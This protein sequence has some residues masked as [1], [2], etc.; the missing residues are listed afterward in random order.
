MEG[1]WIIFFNWLWRDSLCA[2]DSLLLNVLG[3][4]FWILYWQMYCWLAAGCLLLLLSFS[5]SFFISSHGKGFTDSQKN[6]P[7]KVG[8]LY[9]LPPLLIT[10][11]SELTLFTTPLLILSRHYWCFFRNIFHITRQV[12]LGR[13]GWKTFQVSISL[14]WLY[15]CHSSGSET[16]SIGDWR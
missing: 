11:G 2:I 1:E 12:C 15:H 4:M 13:W 6:G 16:S 3:T 10:W 7:K 8:P 14:W 5:F 9:S